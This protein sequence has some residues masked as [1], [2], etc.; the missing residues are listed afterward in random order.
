MSDILVI[1]WAVWLALQVCR[2]LPLRRSARVERGDVMKALFTGFCLIALVL[3]SARGEASTIIFN[4]SDS[5]FDA[6][7]DNQ[8]W[9]SPTVDNASTNDNYLTGEL[10]GDEFTFDL[11][12]SFFTFDLST[13]N[14]SG[15]TLTSATLEVVRYGF[16]SSG[17]S[18]TLELFDVSTPAATLNNNAGTSAAIFAD[19][20]SGSSYGSFLVPAYAFSTSVTLTFS[21]NA[22][23]LADIATGA[24]GFFSIGGSLQS[25]S[26]GGGDAFLFGGSSGAGIQRLILE[27]APAASTVPEP[28]SILLLGSGLVGAYRVRER[29]QSR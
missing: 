6:G 10:V 29:R 12:R 25:I 24:G 8:G 20:G 2:F 3:C 9:W 1:A 22:S 11:F 19:L 17:P 5:Q 13:L 7:V 23:A 14:L 18:E 16:E 21:L 15:Q 4:T 26:P 28:T 27:T